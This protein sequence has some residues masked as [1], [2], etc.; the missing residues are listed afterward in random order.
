MRKGWLISIR[1]ALFLLF[2]FASIIIAIRFWPASNSSEITNACNPTAPQSTGTP[3][4]TAQT[5]PLYLGLY[6]R[7]AQRFGLD[8]AV[9]A[10]IGKLECNHG[11][12]P[13]PSCS[14]SGAVNPAG[15]GGPMQFL[16]ATWNGYGLDGDGDGRADFAMWRLRFALFEESKC[17]RDAC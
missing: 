10:G 15:A 7:A 2:L 8:W 5:P 12:D 3:S 1:V 14:R 16:A 13:D 6:E 4:P 17:R 9:I 11:R